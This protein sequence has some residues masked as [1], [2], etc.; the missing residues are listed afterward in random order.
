MDLAHNRIWIE[1]YTWTDKVVLDAVIRAFARGVD[2][3]VILE[4]NVF[5]TPT[6]NKS[7]YEALKQKGIPVSYAD[8]ER[9]VFT[10]A[11]FIIIDDRFYISTG[12]LTQ[13]FFTKNRD[14]ILSDTSREVLSFLIDIFE[15][16]F[17]HLGTEDIF[18]IPSNLVFSPVNS[19][20]K[21]GSFLGEAKSR[22]IIYTQTL[23]DEEILSILTNLIKQKREVQICTAKNESNTQSEKY[24]HFSW[25]KIA[26]PYLHAKV[27][28]IDE[29]SLFIGSQNLTQ[30]S[31]DNNREIGII[32]RSNT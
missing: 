25:K 27:I 21:I 23:Q 1:I 12:N 11:K 7:I 6:I 16:D 2:V 26:K 17:S 15:R 9:Y 4:P 14:F 8:G 10:H 20:E 19:R 31:L 22:V 32:I 5:G 24:G 3:R 30:N 28:F 13:S 18:P 29:N